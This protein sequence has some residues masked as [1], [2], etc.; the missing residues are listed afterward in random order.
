MRNGA[1][2]RSII[3]A[4][5]PGIQSP[6]R[7]CAFATDAVRPSVHRKPLVLE[8]VVRCPVERGL[9]SRH[10]EPDAGFD[11]RAAV[12]SEQSV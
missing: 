10:P 4:R 2:H 8:S 1:T 3:D 7:N 6:P 5:C 11:G 9:F 12:W